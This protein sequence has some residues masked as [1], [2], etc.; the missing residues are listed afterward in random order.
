MNATKKKSTAAP[1]ISA[2]GTSSVTLRVRREH[3]REMDKIAKRKGIVRSAAIQI[4]IAEFIERDG[5]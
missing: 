3:L 1:E 2:D 5:K 4:A